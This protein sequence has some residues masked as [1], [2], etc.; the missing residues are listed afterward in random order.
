M[1]L[2]EAYNRV[3]LETDFLPDGATNRPGGKWEKSSI[4]IHETANSAVGADAKAHARYLEGPDAKRRRVSW[5]YTVDKDRVIKHLPLSERSWHTSSSRANAGS[6]SMELCVNQDGDF[7]ATC[8]R[9]ALLTAI[10]LYEYGWEPGTKR[11]KQHHSW[12][13]KDC[14]ALLRSDGRA[15]TSFIG[16]VTSYWEALQKG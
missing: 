9:A 15:W 12:T 7:R 6:I 8:D 1:T 14:P 2:T 4:T 5:H 16:R 3:G 11:I 10:L 13:G